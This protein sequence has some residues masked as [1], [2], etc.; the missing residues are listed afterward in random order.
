ML[1]NVVLYVL[2]REIAVAQKKQQMSTKPTLP[3]ANPAELAQMGI[4]ASV[5]KDRSPSSSSLLGVG[6]PCS[7]CD[8]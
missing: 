5:T 7:E 4:D 3:N 6:C 2:S 8:Q 1:P